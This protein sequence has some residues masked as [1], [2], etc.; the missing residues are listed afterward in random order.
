MKTDRIESFSDFSC[1]WRK[2]SPLPARFSPEGSA[3]RDVRQRRMLRRLAKSKRFERWLV[4]QDSE[5]S[6]RRVIR[7]LNK[8]PADRLAAYLHFK[9][10]ECQF[11]IKLHLL[12]FRFI[13]FWKELVEAVI[14]SYL[15]LGSIA[16]SKKLMRTRFCIICSNMLKI[17]EKSKM[18]IWVCFICSDLL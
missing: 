8:S 6:A 5:L 3:P 13:Y 18:K 10:H 11:L 4:D 7:C 2:A 15:N 14:L 16:S 17:D 1:R 9:W 12:N